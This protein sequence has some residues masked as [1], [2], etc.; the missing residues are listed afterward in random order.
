[1]STG[2]KDTRSAILNATWQLLEESDGSLVRMSDIAKRAGVSRQAIYLHFETRVDLLRETT[3]FV[4]QENNI[5]DRLAASRA[6]KSGKERL[7]AFIEAWGNYIPVVHP[8]CRVLMATSDTDPAAAEAWAG[9]MAAVRHGCAAAIKALAADKAL[10]DGLSIEEATD[11]LQM[12]LSVRNW[13]HLT[14]E[15][16]WSQERYIAQ[17]KRMAA[18][19]LV[20]R[21]RPRSMAVR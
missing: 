2:A 4:D 17:L 14:Q 15:C 10:A 16:G 21:R 20:W 11:V 6:A 19:T 5:D 12:L 13:E 18:D 1:M 8:V 7:S 9:R 3:L